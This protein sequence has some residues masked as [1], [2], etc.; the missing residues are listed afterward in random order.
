M[1]DFGISRALHEA[2][3]TGTR[4]TMGTPAYMSPEQAGG[5]EI[6]PAS[7]VFVLGSVLAYAATGNAPFDGGAPLSVIYRIVHAEPDLSALPP[8]LTLPA[9]CKVKVR[10]PAC[11]W[12][13][14]ASWPAELLAAALRKIRPGAN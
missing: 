9:T 5:G 14:A 12:M 13:V 1:I 6:G 4:T 7:D 2:A 3:I 11:T 8:A 10:V